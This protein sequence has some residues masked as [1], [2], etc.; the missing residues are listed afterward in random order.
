M[1]KFGGSSVADAASIKR[2]AQRIVDTKARG[3]EVVVVISAMGDT[4]DEL[5]DLA[6]EARLGTPNPTNALVVNLLYS[7]LVG[8]LPPGP[9]FRYF[10]GLLD[11]GQMSQVD[12]GILAAE[13]ELNLE[14][15]DFAG[16]SEIGVGFIPYG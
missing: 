12:L 11:S 14:N 9:D 8:F 6:L 13:N 10:V 16:I 7:N 5:M 4:T 15:I 1:Q 2:V 3:A